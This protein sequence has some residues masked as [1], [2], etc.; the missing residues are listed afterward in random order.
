MSSLV[1]SVKGVLEAIGADWADVS[2][3]GVTLR[4]SV[5][6]G[7]AERLGQVGDEVRL[8]S[9]LQVREDSMTLYGFATEE[10]RSA[11]ETLIGVNGVGPRVALSVLSRLTP[12]SLV[13]AIGAGDTGAFSGVPGVG[14]KTASRIV[15][16]LKG[17]L[18]GDWAV[19]MSSGG[20]GDVIE[21][22][23]ALGYTPMEAREAVSSLP[24]ANGSSLED[25]VR[26]ALQ[27]IGGG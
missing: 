7:T 2:L 18:D 9:S 27:R 24:P 22:L 26:Q 11:F 20:D 12:E 21:A 3:G 23:A 8:F 15:L 25:R 4:L 16:E 17:K 14:K 1:S 5:P 6:T 13:E 19:P 10:A